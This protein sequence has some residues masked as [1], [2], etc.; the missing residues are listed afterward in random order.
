[1]DVAAR[2][3]QLVQLQRSGVLSDDE[4]AA[5]KAQVLGGRVEPNGL[6]VSPE[7]VLR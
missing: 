2:L 7:T 4:F 5:V 3:E 6:N 1:M